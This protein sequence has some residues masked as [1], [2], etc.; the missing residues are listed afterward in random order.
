MPDGHFST[1][2]ANPRIVHATTLKITDWGDHADSRIWI[3]GEDEAGHPFAVRYSLP[4]G[5]NVEFTRFLLAPGAVA[6]VEPM[7]PM[8]PGGAIRVV[9]GNSRAPVDEQSARIERRARRIGEAEMGRP[10]PDDYW[11]VLWTYY[12]DAADIREAMQV[13]R[14]HQRAIEEIAGQ[15]AA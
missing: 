9:P 12:Q 2:P 1:G 13:Y 10:F 4:A 6:D 7:E 15:V 14:W 3:D 11:T 8:P 5:V